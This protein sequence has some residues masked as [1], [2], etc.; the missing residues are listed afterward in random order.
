VPARDEAG[1]I[2]ALVAD[3]KVQTAIPD[4][5]VLICDD[6][7]TDGTGTAATTAIGNDPRFSLLTNHQAPPAGWVGK[8]HAL[9][10]LT[11]QITTGTLVFLDADIRVSPHALQQAVGTVSATGGLLTIWP[12]QVAGSLLE[13]LLQPLL[14]WSWLGSVPLGISE[15]IRARSMAVA[16]GQFLATSVA[17]YRRAGG[18]R[19][20][21]GA[22]VEDLALARRYRESGLPTAIR[23]GRTI[24]SCRM[25]DGPQDT[26]RG[27]RRWL[28]TEFG[29]PIGAVGVATI[30]G[31]VYVAP[32][33]ALLTR[34]HRARAAVSVG[35]AVASRLVSRRAE[36][37]GL[38]RQDVASALAHP[39]SIALAIAAVTDSLR[40]RRRGTL[41]W[42]GRGLAPL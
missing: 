22:I 16:N 34:R 18:H 3:L 14:C 36:T 31:A 27:Y 12:A 25:Y 39:V 1:R 29:S 7:S 37:G 10:L 6:D 11:A 35:A 23:S 20:V 28:S 13:H 21:R 42:K 32:V 4:L 17:D 8:A 40:A 15:R 30:A 9:D 24:A 19:A 2:A 26:W 33:A 38:T 5:H 41:E